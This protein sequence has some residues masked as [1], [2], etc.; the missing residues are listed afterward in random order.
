MAKT[1]K[2][3]LYNNVDFIV[4]LA[5]FFKIRDAFSPLPCLS[6]LQYAFSTN[7]YDYMFCIHFA[8]FLLKIFMIFM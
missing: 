7:D 8:T 2:K 5:I 1:K 4:T 3:F 6:F